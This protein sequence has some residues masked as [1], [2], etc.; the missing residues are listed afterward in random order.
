[1]AYDIYYQMQSNGDITCISHAHAV[2][3]RLHFSTYIPPY[4]RV[5]EA[6][7]VYTARRRSSARFP[8]LGTHRRGL[9]IS[10]A[11]AYFTACNCASSKGINFSTRITV[12]R[13]D[14]GDTKNAF[15]ETGCAKGWS[16]ARLSGYYLTLYYR[17]TSRISTPV[18][19]SYGAITVA[20]ATRSP[21]SVQSWRPYSRG[22]AQPD[23]RH[24]HRQPRNTENMMLRGDLVRLG[25]ARQAR[26]RRCPDLVEAVRQ[27]IICYDS[28][29]I[30]CNG[31]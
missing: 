31:H 4:G 3:S 12:T 9:G 14:Q 10:F 23:K 18:A 21:V 19:K 6:A 17:T 16:S 26:H 11:D 27:F 15:K 22:T 2:S 25:N 1:M 30:I 8:E 5:H 28:T 29:C 7:R 20:G 13:A 24:A